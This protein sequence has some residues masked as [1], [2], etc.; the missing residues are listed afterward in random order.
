MDTASFDWEKALV[1][2]AGREEPLMPGTQDMLSMYY[3]AVLQ[4]PRSGNLSFVIATGRKVDRYRFDVIGEET[5][6]T[7]LGER[8]ALRLSAKNGSDTIELWIA[9]DLRG[10]PVK[11]RFIDRKGEIFDQL[12]EEI[13]LGEKP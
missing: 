3:Q 12:A 7:G 1:R 8:R 5:V 4:P 10:L 11:I 2:Y 13:S 9:S 6:T